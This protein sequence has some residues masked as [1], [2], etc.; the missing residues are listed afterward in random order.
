MEEVKPIFIVCGCMKY[1]IYLEAAIRRFTRPTWITVGFIGDMTISE[2]HKDGDI[3]YLPV[4]DKYEDLPRKIYAAFSWVSSTYP[5]SPGIY[6]TDDDI[7][8]NDIQILEDEILKNRETPYWGLHTSYCKSAN[9]IQ[10]HKFED[11]TLHPTHQT[12]EYCYGHGYWIN[13][14]SLLFI[15]NSKKDYDESYLEDVCTG[16]VMNSYGIYPVHIPVP[17]KEIERGPELLV[18]K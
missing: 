7:V 14:D 17:Y 16:Y 9:I 10:L 12:A 15:L 2:P 13:R 18:A 6:K 3:V 5:N 11:K 4:S 1:K 8:Y